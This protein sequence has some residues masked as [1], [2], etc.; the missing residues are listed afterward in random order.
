MAQTLITPEAATASVADDVVHWITCH[1]DNLSLCGIS[2]TDHSW[3]DEE[4]DCPLCCLIVEEDLPCP[5]EEKCHCS[6]E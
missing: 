4:P 6:S 5:P 3:T 2:L 1:D